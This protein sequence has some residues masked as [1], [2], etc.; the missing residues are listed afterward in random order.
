M[1]ISSLKAGW[2]GIPSSGVQYRVLCKL[3]YGEN[4]DI[5]RDLRYWGGR[6]RGIQPYSRKGEQNVYVTV[7]S[8]TDR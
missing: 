5:S 8:K 6:G 4:M 2:V 1:G 3:L 7:R